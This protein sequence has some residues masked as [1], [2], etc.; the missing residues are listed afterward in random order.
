MS[1]NNQLWSLIQ[2]IT[3]QLEEVIDQDSQ[4][5]ESL[6]DLAQRLQRII[7]LHQKCNEAE[8]KMRIKQLTLMRER[9][10]YL[11]KYRKIENLGE[12]LEW[13]DQH[14]ILPTIHSIMFESGDDE[15]E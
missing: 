6:S 10:L 2:Q 13:Q 15:E 7:N 9:N 8:Q 3:V 5:Q 4:T 1:N 12:E 14:D 11:E